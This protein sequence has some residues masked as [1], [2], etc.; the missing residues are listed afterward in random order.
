ML[1]LYGLN[2]TGRKNGVDEEQQR[3]KRKAIVKQ[4]VN[5]GTAH[6]AGRLL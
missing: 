4:V 3:S 5:G 6:I 2:I 1:P